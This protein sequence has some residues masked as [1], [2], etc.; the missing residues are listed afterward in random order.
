MDELVAEFGDAIHV[1]YHFCSV[2]GDAHRKISDRWGAGDEGFG[3]YGA[4]VRKTVDRFEHVDVHPEVWSKAPPRSSLSPHLFLRAVELAEHAGEAPQR[5]F[6]ELT[7]R[8]RHAFFAEA[9]DVSTW[10]E[11]CALAEAHGLKPDVVRQKLESGAAAAALSRDFE[12]VRS[13]D[14]TV[15]PTVIF[16]EGRQRLNGNVGF[17][18]LEA[19]VRELLR[20]P[21][22]EASWC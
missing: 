18:I 4:H 6:L 12:L 13:Y 14:V 5:S 17:R 11:Q 3:S 21:D 7:A 2:F 9:R 19:N 22:R 1:H 20:A 16:N 10:N 8:L 15:S